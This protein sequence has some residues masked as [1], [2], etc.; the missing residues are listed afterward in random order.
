MEYPPGTGLDRRG[1]G[2]R[3]DGERV[4][5]GERSGLTIRPSRPAGPGSYPGQQ[6]APLRQSSH[7]VRMPVVLGHIGCSRW[8]AGTA[9]PEAVPA[10]LGVRECDGELYWVRAAGLTGET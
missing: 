10:A 1:G 7:A 2:L 5:D 6:A 9:F 8:S 3:G 4:N